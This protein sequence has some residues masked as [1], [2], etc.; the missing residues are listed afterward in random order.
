MLEEISPEVMEDDFEV[1]GLELK[2]DDLSEVE[3]KPVN[4]L[5]DKE[6]GAAA[7]RDC[8]LDCVPTRLANLPTKALYSIFSCRPPDDTQYPVFTDA[9]RYPLLLTQFPA[10]DIKIKGLR[11]SSRGACD[12]S[13]PLWHAR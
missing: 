6:V 3:D 8:D 13:C 9:L 7:G 11:L 1:E 10:M 2:E 5:E 12:Q 4:K